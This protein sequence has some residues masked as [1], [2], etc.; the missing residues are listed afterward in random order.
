MSII[1]SK[2]DARAGDFEGTAA[3]IRETWFELLDIYA[4]NETTPEELA[5][6]YELI[7]GG[8]EAGFMSVKDARGFI[9]RGE[10]FTDAH[11][12]RLS[13]ES[14]NKDK[15]LPI[16]VEMLQKQAPDF[17]KALFLANREKGREI[18]E[19]LHMS[20]FESTS[21]KG[22]GHW[23]HGGIRQGSTNRPGKPRRV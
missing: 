1:L 8:F 13:V 17:L 9:R 10:A 19:R 18:M 15:N 7:K 14:M 12:M 16:T 2:W 11:Y 4:R 6:V 22:V 3:K 21:G 5:A 20:N 23:N